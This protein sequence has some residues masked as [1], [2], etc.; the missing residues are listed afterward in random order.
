MVDSVPG[1]FELALKS[2]ASKLKRYILRAL[3]RRRKVAKP[4][5]R[6]AAK[7]A[8]QQPKPRARLGNGPAG[9]PQTQ[10]RL[11]SSPWPSAGAISFGNSAAV[12]RTPYSGIMRATMRKDR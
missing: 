7:K 11:T 8:K 3:K 9:P 6:G 1:P 12:A 5:K 2:L 4:R 10:C